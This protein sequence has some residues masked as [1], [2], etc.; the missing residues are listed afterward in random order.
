MIEG[1]NGTYLMFK[2]NAYVVVTWKVQYT[3]L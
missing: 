3:T 2:L 1:I